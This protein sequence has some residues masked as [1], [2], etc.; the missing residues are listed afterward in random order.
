MIYAFFAWKWE[1]RKNRLIYAEKPADVINLGSTYA[2]YGF[3]Y[4]ADSSVCYNLANVPQYL[5][6]DFK[7]LKKY[8]KCLRPGSKCLLVLPDFI[9]ASAGTN[10]KKKNYYEIFWP[11][12]LENYDWLFLC[13]LLALAMLEPFTHKYES[14]RNKWR[15]HIAS[16]SEKEEHAKSRIH[17]WEKGI[18]VPSV[19]EGYVPQKLENNIQQNKEVLKKIIAYCKSR[20]AEPILLIPPVSSIMQLSV[21]RDCLEA[22]LYAPVREVMQETGVRLLDYYASYPSP[23]LYLNSDCLNEVGRKAFTK[24]VLSSLFDP[25]Q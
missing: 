3:D 9:F 14:E 24:E 18:G 21:S 4:S 6:M 25:R 15:G 19:K 20:G 1:R 16:Q 10:T 7:I 12:Q 2:Y 17:D 11:W 23:D 8:S 5:D 13:K 22:Y